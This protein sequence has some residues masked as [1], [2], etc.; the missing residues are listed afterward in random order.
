MHPVDHMYRLVKDIESYPHYMDG[1][2]GAEVLEHGEEHLIARLDLS[3][4]GIRHSFV[5]RNSLMPSERI[6]M[7]LIEGPFKSLVGEWVF[8]P[9]SKKACKVSLNLTVA[10]ENAMLVA[11]ANRWFDSVANE[12]VDSLCKRANHVAKELL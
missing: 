2:I 4:L 8:L 6:S 11:A 3:K 10:F 7:E 12:L 1:C 5:T 9:L